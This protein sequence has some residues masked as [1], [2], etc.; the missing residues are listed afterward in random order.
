[1]CLVAGSVNRSD[2]DDLLPRRV[3]K[4]SSRKTEHTKCNE[5]NPNCLHNA[6]FACGQW[7][8]TP[9]IV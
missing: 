6:F 7:Q 5:N 3:R 4:T 1:M 8:S 9:T 2:I